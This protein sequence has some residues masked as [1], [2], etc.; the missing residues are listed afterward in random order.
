LLLNSSWKIT[1]A[2]LGQKIIPT[3]SDDTDDSEVLLADID[4][5]LSELD[6]DSE[7]EELEEK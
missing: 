2:P 5:E 3:L 7:L 6:D 1:S 4:E